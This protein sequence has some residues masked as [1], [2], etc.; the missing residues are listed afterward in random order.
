MLI[1]GHL[2]SKS[3]KDRGAVCGGSP[4]CLKAARS[5]T[6][7]SVC[8]HPHLHTAPQSRALRCV[9]DGWYVTQDRALGFWHLCL[10]NLRLFCHLLQVRGTERRGCFI[11]GSLPEK[12]F[13][14]PN[15]Q[16]LAQLLL[17]LPCPVSEEHGWTLGAFFFFDISLW[18]L[19]SA[20]MMFLM[21][22]NPRI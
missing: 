5:S 20:S 11:T 9:A 7:C 2:T 19:S 12:I 16:G 8:T 21:K 4:W 13:K 15:L 22:V 14:N 1:F 3:H 18:H 10:R 6:H 17:R